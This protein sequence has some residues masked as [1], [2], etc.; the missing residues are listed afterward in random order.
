[1]KRITLTLLSATALC[2]GLAACGTPANAATL[3]SYSN[4]VGTATF[5]I[6]NAFTVE[7]GTGVVLVTERNGTTYSYADATGGTWAKIVADPEFVKRYANVAGTNRWHNVTQALYTSCYSGGTQSVIAWPYGVA[8][9]F[10][11]DSCA[12]VAAVRAAGK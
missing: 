10:I 12:F 5:S 2:F 8:P 1:M 3:D 4:D 6:D 9:T 7:R 11:A